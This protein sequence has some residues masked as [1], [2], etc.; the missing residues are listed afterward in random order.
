[1]SAGAAVSVSAAAGVSVFA[2]ELEAVFEFDAGAL[3]LLPPHAVINT[4]IETES[5]VHKNFLLN[6]FIVVYLPFRS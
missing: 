2:S 3:S 6:F 5:N 4:S 1:M